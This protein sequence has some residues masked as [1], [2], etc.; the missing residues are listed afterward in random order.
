M[1]TKKLRSTFRSRANKYRIK[2]I[3]TLDYYID[4]YDLRYPLW[5]DLSKVLEALIYDNHL[6]VIDHI[7]NILSGGYY[8][9]DILTDYKEMKKI[10]MYI[11]RY[12]TYRRLQEDIERGI[13][14]LKLYES[15][16]Y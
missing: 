1:D 12:V 2:A 3:N 15:I 11:L 9:D 14:N 13:E 16:E 5:S 6:T 7:H 8:T 4:G 10:Y